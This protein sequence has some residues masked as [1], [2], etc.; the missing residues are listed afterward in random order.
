MGA[1]DQSLEDGPSDRRGGRE[2]GEDRVWEVTFEVRVEF[3]VKE[4]SGK[5]PGTKFKS[6]M[7]F[8]TNRRFGEVS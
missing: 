2:K 4:T 8:D 5:V 3:T 1:T 6:G 7:S